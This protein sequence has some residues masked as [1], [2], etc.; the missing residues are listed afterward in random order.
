MTIGD[1]STT[2]FCGQC[3]V[4][5][6]ETTSTPPPHH[7]QLFPILRL[8]EWGDDVLADRYPKTIS[9]NPAG[10]Y[11]VGNTHRG[12]GGNLAPD[13]ALT[14]YEIVGCFFDLIIT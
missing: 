2:I 6:G 13:I 5:V 10:F 9:S 14:P 7:D 4:I 11:R 1:S 12:H 8:A 3:G